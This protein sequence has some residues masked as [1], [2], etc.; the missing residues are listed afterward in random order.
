MHEVISDHEIE[1]VVT[2]EK[3]NEILSFLALSRTPTY[4]F[5]CGKLSSS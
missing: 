5:M 2:E 4:R 1:I 3:Q